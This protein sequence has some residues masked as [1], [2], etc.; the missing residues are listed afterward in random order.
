MNPVEPIFT[1]ELFPGLSA[2]LLGVLKSLPP[3]AWELPTACADWTV[4]DV[5]AHLL[6]G[7]LSRLVLRAR[8]AGSSAA[9]RPQNGL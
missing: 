2:E 3:A 6:G 8:P 9:G 5:T 4:K 7:T 1:V